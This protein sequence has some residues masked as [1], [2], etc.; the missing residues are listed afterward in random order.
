MTGIISQ[1]Q[2]EI[3]FQVYIYEHITLE[4]VIGISNSNIAIL[5][6][7]KYLCA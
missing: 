1:R 6:F 2:A 3:P 5:R 7:S 4:Q